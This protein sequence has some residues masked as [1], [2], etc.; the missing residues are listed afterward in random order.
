[1]VD[2]QYQ[3]RNTASRDR[4]KP[5][6]QASYDNLGI[7]N[8][9][10]QVLAVVVVV[11]V[12]IVAYRAQSQKERRSTTSVAPYSVLVRNNFT[13]DYGERRRV[14]RLLR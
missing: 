13:G 5:G 9:V 2:S 6:S 8:P 11:V 1:M 10:G 3:N 14:H 4:T 12:G 7:A